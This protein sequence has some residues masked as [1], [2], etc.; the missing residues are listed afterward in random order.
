M[1]SVT[2]DVMSHFMVLGVS[3]QMRITQLEG[4]VAARDARI[5]QLEGQVAARDA[6]IA[7][8]VAQV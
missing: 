1:D 2:M 5:A 4:Q 3:P 6:R 7:Q 8:L